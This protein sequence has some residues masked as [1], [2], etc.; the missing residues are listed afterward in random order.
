MTT[1][2]E[3]REAS[4]AGALGTESDTA[5]GSDI[6]LLERHKPLLRFDRQ[7]DYQ[8]ASVLGMVREPGQSAAQLG[9]GRGRQR[10]RRPG[11]GRARPADP[12]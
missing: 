6:S 4:V 1:R 7:Y 5:P 11:A 3:T 9:P 12:L 8:L 10:R 2:A